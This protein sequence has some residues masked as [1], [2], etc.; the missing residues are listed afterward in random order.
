MKNFIGEKMIEG[1]NDITQGN[2]GAIGFVKDLIKKYPKR[3]EDCFSIFRKYNIIGSKVYIFWNDCCDR[4][5]EVFF[6]TID[7]IKEGIVD[8]EELTCCLEDSRP[9]HLVS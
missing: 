3:I 9:W 5:W 8:E 4:D 7:T 2:P 6:I 1:I